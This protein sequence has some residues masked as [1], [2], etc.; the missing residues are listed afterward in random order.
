MKYILI[1]GSSRGLGLEIAKQLEDSNTSLIITGR[2]N[3]TLQ[4]ASKEL[5]Y[6]KNHIFLQIDFEKELYKLIDLINNQQIFLN[7][8][9]HNLGVKLPSDSHPID[10]KILDKTLKLNLY[11]AIEINSSFIKNVLSSY[12]KIIHIGSNIGENGNSSPAYSI[13]K[14]ALNTYIKNIARYYAMDNI[15][16]CAVLPG[17]M[18]HDGSDWSIKKIEKFS[19]YEEVKN[20]LPLG[21]YCSTK[22]VATFVKKIYNLDIDLINGSLFKIDGGV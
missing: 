3:L 21:K 7:G 4:N 19:R 10:M 5:S 1:T 22:D 18:D 2:N 8:I 6:S 15:S 9:I 17:A 14:G 12:C 20:S 16:I 11:T 13:S